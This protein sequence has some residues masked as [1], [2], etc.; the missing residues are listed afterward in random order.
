MSWSKTPLNRADILALLAHDEEHA[1]RRLAEYLRLSFIPPVSEVAPKLI[2]DIQAGDIQHEPVSPNDIQ[3]TM[4]PRARFW[5]ITGYEAFQTP[6]RPRPSDHGAMPYDVPPQTSQAPPARFHP[7]ASPKHWLPRL[8]RYWAG[9]ASGRRIDIPKLVGRI[10]QAQALTRIPRAQRH[11]AVHH[12]HLIQD[13]QAHLLPY[14]FDQA[15][16]ALLCAARLPG[17][18]SSH[19]LLLDYGGELLAVDDDHVSTGRPP[20]NH[21]LVIIFSD[22]G[23]LSLERARAVAMW[24]RLIEQLTRRHCRVVVITPCQAEAIDPRLQRLVSIE[25]WNTPSARSLLPL[26]ALHGQAECLITLLAPA[27]RIEI[28]LIRALRLALNQQGHTLPAEVEAQVW[29]H[30]FIQHQSTVAAT[31]DTQLRKQYLKSFEQQDEALRQLALDVIG[32]WHRQSDEFTEHVWYEE[33]TSLGEASRCLIPGQ[34]IA[35]ANRYFQQLAADL[36]LGDRRLVDTNTRYW[37][38]QVETRLPDSATLLPE[39]G[40]ALQLISSNLHRHQ[41]GSRSPLRI[42][43]Q[44]LPPSDQPERI[45]GIY[46]QADRLWLRSYQPFSDPPRNHSLIGILSARREEIVITNQGDSSGET[47]HLRSKDEQPVSTRSLNSGSPLIIRSDMETLLL[48]TM[49]RPAWAKNAGRD[50]YGLFADLVFKGIV[51]RFRWIPPGQFWMGSPDDEHARADN[52]DYHVVKLTKGFWLA[53][54]VVTQALWK[55]VMGENRSHFKGEERP[56]DSVSWEDAQTFIAKLNSTTKSLAARL[57]REAEWEYACRAGT[58]TPFSFGE[59]ITPAQVNYDGNYPYRGEEEGQYRK[60]T[61]IVKSLPANS[62]GLYEMHGNVWEWCEDYWQARL[63][64]VAVRD[65]IGPGDGSYRVI[66]GGSWFHD[67]GD[68]RSAC[69]YRD[70]PGYGNH[71]DGFRLALGH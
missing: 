67:G 66:R 12:V 40:A 26:A 28:G 20:P 2:A 43:P 49:Q 13:R 33:I 41:S 7:L 47:L 52:E 23:A 62:W 42:N 4:V 63:G 30:P 53:D 61:V 22:L 16:G 25:P 68:V 55:R 29:Q 10:S 37:F 3:P 1:A 5:A 27:T 70:S 24:L 60:K 36:E 71:F 65:P 18:L 48:G 35:S 50:R 51:Q 9:A 46:Q 57:P 6:D 45:V 39:V 34:D 8:D 54:T 19:A 58:L 17:S 38:S 31:P 59:Q 15:M 14:L 32:R 21:S 64:E 44:D 56:V 69:R 11:N